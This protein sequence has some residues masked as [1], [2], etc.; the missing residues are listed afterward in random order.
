MSKASRQSQVGDQVSTDFSG[1]ITEHRIT[2]RFEASPRTSQSG[3]M[4]KVSP[5]VPR[6]SG[7]PIDA[8]WFEPSPSQEPRP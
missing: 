1:K 6:S 3:V 2:E 4:F 5:A 7:D 8:D